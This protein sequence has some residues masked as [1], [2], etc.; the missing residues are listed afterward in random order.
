VTVEQ[1]EKKLAI[2]HPWPASCNRLRD[3]ASDRLPPPP[4]TET[5]GE[6]TA[7]VR[8]LDFAMEDPAGGDGLRLSDCDSDRPWV[9]PLPRWFEQAVGLAHY[10]LDQSAL[11]IE[12]GVGEESKLQRRCM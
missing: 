7:A 6:R 4:L 10:G 5:S 8:A 9:R 2:D 12:A 1:I 11:R 3:L